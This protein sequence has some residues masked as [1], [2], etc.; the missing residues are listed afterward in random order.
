[1]PILKTNH[2]FPVTSSQSLTF[3]TV[4]LHIHYK[5]YKLTFKNIIAVHNHEADYSDTC[6][7]EEE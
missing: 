4:E 3:Q 1:M 5:W 7:S 2:Q 6:I